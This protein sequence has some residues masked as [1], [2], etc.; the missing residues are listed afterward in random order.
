MCNLFKVNNKNPRMTSL[1]SFG[2]FIV[3]PNKAG[4]FEGNFSLGG[5]GGS[6]FDPPS[7]FKK[8]LSNFNITLYNC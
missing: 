2:V 1:M 7:Y 3:N 8:N 4:I 6:Q 5:A